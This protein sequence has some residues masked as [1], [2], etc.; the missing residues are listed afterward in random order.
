M[1]FTRNPD[2]IAGALKKIGAL[3]EGSRVEN[4]EAEEASH[5]FFGEALG[6]S[7]WNPMATHPPLVERIRRI[8]PSFTGDFSEVSLEPPRSRRIAEAV[9]AAQAR[10]PSR[11][12]TRKTAMRFNPAEAISGVG[13]LEPQNL[14]YAAA[15]LASL[16]EPVTGLAHEPFGACAL[17]YALLLDEDESIRAR[18]L[19]RLAEHAPSPIYLQTRKAIPLLEPLSAEARLPLVEMAI[20]ALRR[21]SHA[22]FRDFVENI[23][24]LMEADQRISLFEYALRRMLLRHL[25]PQFGWGEPPKVLYSN[26]AP[27]LEP[28]RILLSALA[29]VGQTDPLAQTNAFRQGVNAL[30]WLTPPPQIA[31][32][33]ATSLKAVDEA[34]NVLAAASPRL[35][36][37]ILNACAACIG[38]DGRVTLEEGELLRAIADS[39]DCPMPPLLAGVQASEPASSEVSETEV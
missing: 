8:D 6:L 10:R 25:G 33:E 7:A 19:A 32:V 24:H 22:Q 3:S 26:E 1:Q 38:A 29:R 14:A 9:A 39:L 15:L 27:L 21:L 4:S 12:A 5:M 18:Q 20:P 23:R 16:P 17:I 28:A 37:P 35:K 34:L 11:Y 13:T 2:G 30:G 31:P 36:K